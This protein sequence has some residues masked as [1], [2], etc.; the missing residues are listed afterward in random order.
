MN[1][2][3]YRNKILSEIPEDAFGF[4]YRITNLTNNNYYIGKKQFYSTTRKKIPGRKNRRVIIK[5]SNW[6]K[7]TS[8]SKELKEQIKRLGVSNFKFEVLAIAKTKGQLSYLEENVQHR[9]GVIVD[10]NCYNNSVGSG[11]SMNMAIDD[12]LKD[13]I[14]NMV[15]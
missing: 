9:L 2:W 1:N 4:V 10:D 5:E 3:I 8:S 12:T 13:A 7:Y 11:K 15:L 6:K 14:K